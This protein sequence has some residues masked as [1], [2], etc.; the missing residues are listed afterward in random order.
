[1]KKFLRRLVFYMIRW[2][3]STFVLAPAIAFFK[4][5]PNM[6]GTK[7][8]W[9][10]AAVS[11]VIGSLIFFFVDMWIFRNKLKNPIWEVKMD[12][13]CTDCGKLCRGYRLIQAKKY[14]RID[15]FP[16]F[17]CEACSIAKY[18]KTLR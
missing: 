14:D 9:I 13:T 17:R 15:A 5:S 12:T 8:D 11:N 2:Q 7:E 16:E 4:H 3:C 1:M 18:D 10:A 6:W